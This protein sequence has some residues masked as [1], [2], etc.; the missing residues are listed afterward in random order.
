M[1]AGGVTKLLRR[2]KDK[3][4]GAKVV[5]LLARD[6]KAEFPDTQGFSPATCAT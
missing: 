5:E 6:L 1:E 2:E 4:W 3:G